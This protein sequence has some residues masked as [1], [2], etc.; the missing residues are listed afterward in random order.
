M[1]IWSLFIYFFY[2]PAL[3][4][5]KSWVRPYIYIHTRIHENHNHIYKLDCLIECIVFF[6]VK[7][8]IALKLD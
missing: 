8:K 2:T 7:G 6:L 5:L 4:S 1:L 3:S